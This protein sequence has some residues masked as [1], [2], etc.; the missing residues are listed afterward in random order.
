MTEAV[1]RKVPPGKAK[2][3][4]KPTSGDAGGRVIERPRQ[5]LESSFE[6]YFRWLIETRR[7]DAALKFLIEMLPELAASS[8]NPQEKLNHLLYMTRMVQAGS[9]AKHGYQK[10]LR[11]VKGV[12]SNI[13]GLSVPPGGAFVEFGCGAHDPVA[14]AT[15][16][17]A[18]GFPEAIGIDLL[19]PRNPFYSAYS[20]YDIIANMRLF[21]KRYCLEGTLPAQLL[22]RIRDFDVRAFE[23]GD[24]DAG[25]AKMN[26]RVRLDV[27]DLSSS[28]LQAG[29]V[30]LLVSFAVFE[31]VS[32]MPAVCKKIY[33]LLRPGG[34]AYHFIDM[35][36]H[37]SYR[38]DGTYHELSF[39][40]ESEAPP[41]MNR[42]RA[43]QQVAA[44]EAAGF[45][46]VRQARDA[47]PMTDE[48]RRSLVPPFSSMREEDVA[49]TKLHLVVR[50]PSSSV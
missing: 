9:G 11:K 19:S 39:L 12:A 28:S 34:I 2:G 50:K 14:L 15:Y 4:P 43:H 25:L 40:T 42:L 47:M 8:V 17:H 27:G 41:N 32:D 10:L 33:D 24:F 20:M 37:R 38:R 44:Q 21:P 49:V 22:Q 16:Y 3:A 7:H 45:E 5:F 23:N 35:A 29:S 6:D 18:N 26:G 48:L 36:D 13:A 31:H 46:I 30:S 1:K